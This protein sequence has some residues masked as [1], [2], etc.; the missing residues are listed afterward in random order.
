MISFRSWPC[1]EP[2][3]AKRELWIP[4]IIELGTGRTERGTIR[5]SN[6]EPT[7]SDQKD[8]AQV[9]L[10]GL[11]G[12]LLAAGRPKEWSS[13]KTSAHFLEGDQALQGEELKMR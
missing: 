10:M 7:D 4:Q 8:V 13:C 9:E 11:T 5:I 1:C 6:L 3:A 12:A 2:G